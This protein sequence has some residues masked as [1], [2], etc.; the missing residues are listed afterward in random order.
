MTVHTLQ[1]MHFFLYIQVTCTRVKYNQYTS[2]R[3]KVLA[4]WLKICRV[5]IKRVLIFLA[6]IV[7]KHIL[8]WGP[9]FVNQNLLS[10]SEIYTEK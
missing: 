8:V 6:G 9:S 10:L 2:C 7:C 1:T 5:M 4:K 3:L